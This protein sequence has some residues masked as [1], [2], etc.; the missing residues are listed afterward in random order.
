M[1]L[2]TYY[3][4]EYERLSKQYPTLF[5]LWMQV[6]DFYEMYH[7]KTMGPNLFQLSTLSQLVVTKKDKHKD[8][9]ITNPYMSGFHIHSLQKYLKVFI[10]QGY[11]IA[12]IDQE[13]SGQ[14]PKRSLSNIYSIGTYIENDITQDTSYM[15]H[16]YI[17]KISNTYMIGVSFIDIMTGRSIISELVSSNSLQEITRFVSMY[18]PKELIITCSC[19]EESIL[20]SLLH[21][22][23]GLIHFYKQLPREFYKLEYQ[24]TFLTKIYGSSEL[25][26]I[27][28]TLHLERYEYGRISF[29]YL[30]H[31]IYTYNHQFILYLKRPFIHNQQFNLKLVGNSIYQLNILNPF[32]SNQKDSLYHILNHTKTN[33]GARYLKY[34]LSNPF[35][36]ET[37]IQLHYDCVNELIYN[38]RYQSIQRL[39]S[40]IYDIEKLIRKCIYKKLTFQELVHWYQSSEYILE[41]IQILHKHTFLKCLIP[42]P[43]ETIVNGLN[44]F[45]ET[46]E[47]TF[48]LEQLSIQSIHDIQ[49]NIFQH[50]TFPDIDELTNSISL[51]INI[52]DMLGTYLEQFIP[53]KKTYITRKHAN[54][55]GYYLCISPSKYKYIEPH[56]ISKS[57]IYISNNV[58]LKTNQLYI[59]SRVKNQIKIYIKQLSTEDEIHRKKLKQIS[60]IKEHYQETLE[61]LIKFETIFE[62]SVEIIQKIDVLASNAYMSVTYH[63]SSPTLISSESSF[64]EVM[65]MRNPIVE[66]INENREF[67]P[68]SIRL[69]CKDQMGILLFGVNSAGKST[70]MKSITMN[71]IMAQCGFHVPCR[72]FRYSI[73]DS[74]FTRISSDDNI[75]KH[76]SSFVMEMNELNMIFE[77]ATKRSFICLDELVKSTEYQSSL[78]INVATICS[79]LDRNITF[80]SATHLHSLLNIK[81]IQTSTSLG[82]YHLEVAYDEA[83]DTLC[84]NRE[85]KKGSGNDNY[86]IKVARHIIKN[87]NFL[88]ICQQT[89]DEV[90]GRPNEF[91]SFKKSKYNSK[92]YVNECFHCKSTQH[93]HTHHIL[94]QKDFTQGVHMQ[95][96]HI[97]KN[98]KYNLMILCEN[99]HQQLHSNLLEL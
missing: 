30:I 28:E 88:Q 37:I 89:S 5:I 80:I 48:I 45:R 9:S 50:G 10:H 64:I 47:T 46:I 16:I 17:E 93:L 29:I 35:T 79:L 53:D 38:D 96:P 24:I 21:P 62:C 75:F 8:E 52:L 71:L 87:T 58:V 91:L 67:I 51:D 69:G 7:Y 72:E 22:W 6:G 43:L 18:A 26:S 78:S 56:L 49:S 39:L 60:K 3:F 15:G 36:D 55:T 73:Y 86:G 81:R 68:H 65:D 83:T 42:L 4:N 77:Q 27:I 98:S 40:N 90:S 97:R 92:M 85:L 61:T 70:L 34:I 59:D 11:T 12:V 57:E 41:L 31:I 23:K 32:I 74:I 84:F 19:M 66:I 94:F 25:M 20:Q 63:Y 14:N 44:L 82:I 2:L 54:K 99:C 76:Q 13:S 1:T 95:K 33:L